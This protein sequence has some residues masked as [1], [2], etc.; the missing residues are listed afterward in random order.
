[1]MQSLTA[2][3]PEQKPAGARLACCRDVS[4]HHLRLC[5]LSLHGAAS[6]LTRSVRLQDGSNPIHLAAWKGNH[7]VIKALIP[8]GGDY[9]V[10]VL[11]ADKFPPWHP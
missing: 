11:H 2:P 1:M 5:L 9:K 10:R 8:L 6:G 4:R 7:D 3:G